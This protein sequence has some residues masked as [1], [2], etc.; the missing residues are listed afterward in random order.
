MTT[1]TQTT[2]PAPG[3]RIIRTITPA[4]QSDLTV[5]SW[6]ADALAAEKAA[7]PGVV[8]TEVIGT[9]GG[10]AATF[11]ALVPLPGVTPLPE[12]EAAYLA[13]LLACTV[14]G[15]AHLPSAV[16]PGPCP[17]C[18][19]PAGVSCEST[20]PSRYENPGE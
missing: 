9:D 3:T 19:A 10:V 8:K 2:T 20:C 13:D 16:C 17:D 15:C 4:G 5:P 11:T 14:C 6:A 18:T 1:T 7:V 12:A